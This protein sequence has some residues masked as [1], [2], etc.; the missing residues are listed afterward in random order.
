MVQGNVGKNPDMLAALARRSRKVRNGFEHVFP[1][2]KRRVIFRGSFGTRRQLAA[3]R[4][5]KIEMR[6]MPQSGPDLC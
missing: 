6:P 3:V 4:C 2:L 1:A 5:L